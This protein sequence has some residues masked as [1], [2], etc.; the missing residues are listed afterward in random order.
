MNA[1]T[2]HGAFRVAPDL[3]LL[4]STIPVPGLGVLPANAYLIHGSEPVLV[5]TGIPAL[6]DATVA[7]VASRIDPASLRWIWLTH[8]DPDHIGAVAA[9][10]ALA[11]AARVVT[12]YLGMGKL[13][14]HL[15]LPP[16]RFFLINPGQRLR[17]GDRELEAVALPS[18]DA[19]ETM[20]V[21]DARA[22]AL[23][24]ADAFGALLSEDDGARAV[25]SASAIDP[26]R[27]RDGL[28]AWTMVDAPWLPDVQPPAFRGRVE[29]LACLAPELVLGAHLAPACDLFT[30]LACYLEAARGARPFVG[31]DQAALDAMLHSAA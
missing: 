24:S 18:Y 4:A 8:T 15:P 26:G 10:L 31:P 13:T 20:G 1:P 21:W 9:L 29:A 25:E 6:A 7:A 5:D 17:A 14:M 22:R 3:D 27:L 23:F 12:N 28:V 30:T 16:E 2:S 11:P 19:P